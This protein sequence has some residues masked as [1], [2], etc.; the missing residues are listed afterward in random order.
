MTDS[1]K[2][3]TIMNMSYTQEKLEIEQIF[4][5]I[6]KS[7]DKNIDK[8]SDWIDKFPK[9]NFSPQQKAIYEAIK[10][11]DHPYRP[12]I[13]KIINDVDPYIIKTLTSNL[14][15][16]AL[17]TGCPKGNKLRAKY[18]CN[19]PGI[20]F[21][22]PTSACNLRCVECRVNESKHVFNLTYKELDDIICQGKELGVYF[23]IYTGGEPL[24]RKKDLIRLCEKHSDCIFICFTNATLIDVKFA[25]EIL[26]VG[27]FIPVITLEGY[28]EA[29]DEFLENDIYQKVIKATALTLL[30][31]KKLIYGISCC[32]TNKNYEYITSEEF[33]DSLIEMGTYFVWYFHYIP[34]ENDAEPELI[35]S[36]K[37][38]TDVYETIHYYRATKPILTLDFLNDTKY[39]NTYTTDNYHYLHINANGDIDPCVFIHESD[40]NIREKTLL[41]ALQSPLLRTY[42]STTNVH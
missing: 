41:E 39:A 40:S 31:E 15:V 32:Y 5:D 3:G 28:E 4:N 29:T 8:L 42:H 38:Q 16:N 7:P 30:R 2:G 36:H 17:L 1:F 10:H 24:V 9:D 25:N 23:Y 21:L 12:Y 37:Q 6:F 13:R 34:S 20:I 33:Y 18:N 22:E 19:I 14:F 27:N 35:P 26:R 11:P